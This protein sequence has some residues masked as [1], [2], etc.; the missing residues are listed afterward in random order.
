MVRHSDTLTFAGITVSRAAL[1]N[2]IARTRYQRVDVEQHVAG[3]TSNPT[4]AWSS[5]FSKKVCAWAAPRGRQVWRMLNKYNKDDLGKQLC[6]WFKI[7]IKTDDAETALAPGLDIKGLR[8]SFAS[9]HLRM[10]QPERFAT[11]DSILSRELG[12]ALKAAEYPHFL[13][14]LQAFRCHYRL[15]EY[16]IGTLETGIF[17]LIK[18]GEFKTLG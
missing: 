5:A 17:L 13:H 7:A 14:E 16:N 3:L 18:N 15:L 12:F 11:L 6:A 10:L 9:K 8:V 1:R 4:P 2:E